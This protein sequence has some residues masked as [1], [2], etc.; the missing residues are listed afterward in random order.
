MKLQ[1]PVR[2]RLLTEELVGFQLYNDTYFN[3]TSVH[4]I[5]IKPVLSNHLSY[6]T[7][8]LCSLGRSHKTGLTVLQ[9]NLSVQ[10]AQMILISLLTIDKG[11]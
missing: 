9:Y 11:K 5:L 10:A 6:L 2:M 4:F 1:L 3:I 7:L 8:F